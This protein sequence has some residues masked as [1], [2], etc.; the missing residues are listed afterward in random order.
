[1]GGGDRH[2]L[3]RLRIEPAIAVTQAAAF[4]QA[5]AIADHR[6]LDFA[7]ERRSRNLAPFG[8]A[9]QPGEERNKPVHRVIVREARKTALSCIKHAAFLRI[10]AKFRKAK[11]RKARKG[12]ERV[13]VRPGLQWPEAESRVLANSPR[14]TQN[15]CANRL[16]GG[17]SLVRDFRLGAAFAVALAGLMLPTTGHAYTPEEQQAC[18][19]DAFRLCSS[20]IPDVDRVTACMVAKKSQLSPQCRAFFRS[21]PEPSARAPAGRPMSIKPA[22]TTAKKPKPKAKTT[23]A[24]PAAT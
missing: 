11:I 1:M 12:R 24:R 17:M 21:G 23:T 13:K 4:D 5:N 14:I 20:E 3:Q 16:L 7:I 2:R 19:P 22:A 6:Q 9:K 10:P 18:Q 8:R 15:P